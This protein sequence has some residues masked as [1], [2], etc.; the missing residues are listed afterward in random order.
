M[1][2][3]PEKG[4]AHFKVTLFDPTSDASSS[5]GASGV[6]SI[7]TREV[8]SAVPNSFLATHWYEPESWRSP[9]VEKSS[10]TRP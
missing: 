8:I 9:E 7:R 2:T 4:A 1:G 10:E 3:L 5:K 6:S